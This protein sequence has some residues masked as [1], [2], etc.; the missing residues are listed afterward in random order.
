MTRS[1]KID[2]WF[3][4]YRSATAQFHNKIDNSE[5]YFPRADLIHGSGG[6]NWGR[7]R[8]GAN[9]TVGRAGG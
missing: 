2:N 5:N 8:C 1:P 7:L 9:A 3:V 4:A 6:E